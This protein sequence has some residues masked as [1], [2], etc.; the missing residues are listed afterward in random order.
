MEHYELSKHIDRA[1]EGCTAEFI[2]SNST[3]IGGIRA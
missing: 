3:N 2:D 1:V